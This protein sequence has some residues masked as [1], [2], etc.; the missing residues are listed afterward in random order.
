MHIRYD[1]T[2]IQVN[3]SE[4]T[5]KKRALFLLCIFRILISIL[6][7]LFKPF[8]QV[9]YISGA[10]ISIQVF[11]ILLLKNNQILFAKIL[12]LLSLCFV[13]V[14]IM[15]HSHPFVKLIFICT[16]PF[17]WFFIDKRFSVIG[18]IISICFTLN[19]KAVYLIKINVINVTSYIL[20]LE[21]L[22][23]ALIVTYNYEIYQ[24]RTEHKIKRLENSVSDLEDALKSKDIFIAGLSHEIRN[25]LGSIIGGIELLLL[26]ISDSN[27]RSILNNA[28]I[29][30]DVLLNI[31]NNLLDAAKLKAN[32]FEIAPVDINV[33]D[34]IEKAIIVQKDKMSAKKIMFHAF[35][36][37]KIP[38]MI[39][40]GCDRLLQILINLMSNA[41]KF[42][43]K[44]G[45]IFM[46]AS[47]VFEK[48]ETL[49]PSKL[50][51]VRCINKINELKKQ[52][53]TEEVQKYQISEEEKSQLALCNRYKTDCDFDKEEM[54]D[55]ILDSDDSL[56]ASKS[57]NITKFKS[58]SD[59]EYKIQHSPFLNYNCIHLHPDS[60]NIDI[61]HLINQ[62]H[63]SKLDQIGDII[64]RSNE[65]LKFEIH[66][67]G[68]GISQENIPKLFKMFSQAEDSIATKYGGTGLG[69]WTCKQ[70]C[71]KMGG[72]IKVYSNPGKG[73]IFVFYIPFVR[74]IQQK[75]E[76]LI[77]PKSS[78]QMKSP[79]ALLIDKLPYNNEIHKAMLLKLNI[80]CELV[81]EGMNAL[82]T[83]FEKPQGYFD[84]IFMDIHMLE[85]NGN[86][87]YKLIRESEK[88]NDR[89]PIDI[90]FISG[91]RD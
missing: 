18:I 55:I 89:K 84:F 24:I 81:E 43:E 91:I 45:S 17:S 72:D 29:C 66:D 58:F 83:Y 70:L 54:Q 52:K 38:N 39:H 74:E 56:L 50:P 51:K 14:A 12:S 87:T 46:I 86:T 22:F 23:I 19:M 75:M 68:C 64:P 77:I 60:Q 62:N 59:I 67:N 3:E 16:I 48:T 7:I 49:E 32:K 88:R 71:H 36:D 33:K 34:S 41:T 21:N 2:T 6:T 37:N 80:E 9:Y 31:L 42:T 25:P 82:K 76:N 47:I 15:I 5:T 44:E 26:K 20:L 65:Y 4:N 90:Y 13:F 40:I 69:L 63:L 57:I 61:K 10:F 35:I 79:R 30:G 53:I 8:M 78:P 28:K 85:V 1:T 27:L 11:I 73:S